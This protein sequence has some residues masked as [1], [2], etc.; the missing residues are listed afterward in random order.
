MLAGQLALVIAALFTGAAVYIN[1]AEQP[2]RLQLDDQSMLSQ[3]KRAYRLGTAMQAPLAIIGFLAGVLAWRQTG[4]WRWLIGAVV[5]IANWP[6]TFI[7]VMPTNKDLMATDPAHAGSQSRRLIRKIGNAARGA[8]RI[9]R[10]RYCHFSVG[11]NELDGSDKGDCALDQESNGVSHLAEISTCLAIRQ[12]ANKAAGPIDRIVRD[13][14]L[15]FVFR[16][17][18]TEQSLAWMFEAIF[19]RSR[20]A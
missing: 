14:L 5:L 9:G 4:D 16:Y 3:W 1:V 8:R 6:Y 11:V 13:H 12:T 19:F 7:G 18:V 15:P 10:G 2:A 20:T 17:L